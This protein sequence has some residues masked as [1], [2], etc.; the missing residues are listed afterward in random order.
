MAW[1]NQPWM[2]MNGVPQQPPQP[3]MVPG[4]MPPNAHMYMGMPGQP[5]PW[6]PMGGAPPPPPMMSHNP[7][8]MNHTP[9]VITQV[10]SSSVA[11]PAAPQPSNFIPSLKWTGA[12]RGY[13]F[14]KRNFG[15]GYYKDTLVSASLCPPFCCCIL[16]IWPWRNRILFF[17]S[18][19]SPQQ[20]LECEFKKMDVVSNAA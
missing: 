11:P 9:L 18:L 7:M 8:M 13:I 5:M 10:S 20:L 2:P 6:M 4:Q 1:N 12:K 17:L 15:Q 16:K 14:T 19:S 3:W